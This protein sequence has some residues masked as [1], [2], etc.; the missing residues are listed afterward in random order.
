MDIFT[1]KQ[2]DQ[3]NVDDAVTP[4]RGAVITNTSIACVTIGKDHYIRVYFQGTDGHLQE[5]ECR[6]GTW[7]RSAKINTEFPAKLNTPLAALSYTWDEKYHVSS[8]FFR[9][10]RHMYSSNEIF[11]V[12]FILRSVSTTSI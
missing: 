9:C 5:S 11:P 1:P 12:F 10:G 4:P 8:I 7:T 2:E 3:G 6:H